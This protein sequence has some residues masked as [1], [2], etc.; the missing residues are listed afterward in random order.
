[1]IV[2]MKSVLIELDDDTAARLERVAPGRSRLRSEFIRRAIRQ[3]LWDVE[4]AATAEAY[5]RHPDSAAAYVDPA[6]WEPPNE[7]G[8]SRS[9]RRR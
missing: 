8:R 6:V 7:S 1:M 5:R 4:E 3:A 2:H 9:R